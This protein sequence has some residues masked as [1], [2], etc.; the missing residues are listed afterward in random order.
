M[1]SLL[2]MTTSSPLRFSFLA[3]LFLLF[4]TAVFS[5]SGRC[6]SVSS[7]M[8][9]GSANIIVEYRDVTTS[10]LFG[11]V[12]WPGDGIVI[13]EV[14]KV[15][16][17]GK[18]ESL[19]SATQGREPLIVLETNDTGEFCHPGLSDGVYVIKFG[20]PGGG[21]NCTWIKVRIARTAPERKVNVGLEI[22]I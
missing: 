6:R 16:R 18:G 20:T 9:A 22:G 3:L 7:D 11:K 17:I 8:S 1:R 13:L 15:D 12:E 10:R 4:S 19:W 2:T 21:W 5:Q 14:F